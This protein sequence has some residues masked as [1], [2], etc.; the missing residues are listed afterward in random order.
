LVV[1]DEQWGPWIEHDDSGRPLAVKPD[2]IV[3]CEMKSDGDILCP[4]PASYLDWHCPG[5]PIAAYRVQR[6]R[7]LLDLI[8]RARGLDDAPEGP[9]R[10]PAPKVTA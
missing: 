2:M 1:T 3:Q 8:E 7:T 9:A 6:P 5:D 4:M 10:P